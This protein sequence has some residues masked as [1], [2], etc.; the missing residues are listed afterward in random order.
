MA[1][2]ADRPGEGADSQGGT[3]VKRDWEVIRSVLEE[4]EGLGEQQFQGAQY[5]YA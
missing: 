2:G 5:A 3:A 4:V 1:Q